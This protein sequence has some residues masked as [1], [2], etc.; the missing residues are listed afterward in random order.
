MEDE[1]IYTEDGDVEPHTPAAAE[2]PAEEAVLEPLAEASVPPED[3]SKHWYI[4]H[5]YS[6]FRAE[7]GGLATQPLAGLWIRG[8]DRTDPDPH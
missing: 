3:P 2:E 4:I 7:G 1:E 6:G 8:A 5:T